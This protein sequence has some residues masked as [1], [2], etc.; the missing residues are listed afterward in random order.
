MSLKGKQPTHWQ[1]KHFKLLTTILSHAIVQTFS[2]KHCSPSYKAPEIALHQ[3]GYLCILGLAPTKI[4]QNLS[5]SGCLSD[6]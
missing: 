5:T 2:A 1:G 6:R 4:K 3:E